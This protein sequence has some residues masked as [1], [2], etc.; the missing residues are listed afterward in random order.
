MK[1]HKIRQLFLGVVLSLTALSVAVT[2]TLHC[3]PLY[4]RDIRS[5]SLP[6]KLGIPEETILRQFD[7]LIAYNRIGGPNELAFPDLPSSEQGLIHFREVKRIFLFFQWGIP[8]GAALSAFGIFR[9]R[10]HKAHYLKYAAFFSLLLPAA[11]G[12]GA[13]FFWDAFFL[14]FHSLMFAN[15]YWLFDMRDD[16]VILLLPDTYFYHCAVMI[17]GILIGFGLLCLLFLANSRRGGYN[18][19]NG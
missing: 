15:D 14:L 13:V 6:E 2:A 11:F 7:T 19:S 10:K 4:V 3:R 1:E 12:A 8:V 16:P 9:F 17:V 18:G 5:L